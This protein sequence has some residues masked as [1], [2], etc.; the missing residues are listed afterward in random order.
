[1]KIP[2][3][4]KNVRKEKSVATR[5]HI[6]ETALTLFAKQGFTATTTKQIAQ[7]AE[8]TEGLIFYYFKTKAEIL[9]ALIET[10]HSFINKL[11]EILQNNTTSSLENLLLHVAKEWLDLLYR[12]KELTILF[13]SMAQINPRVKTALASVMNEGQKQLSIALKQKQKQNEI[14]K[15]FPIDS[16]VQI[17]FASLFNFFLTYNSLPQKSWS[18][19]SNRFTEDLISIW[20]YG[21]KNYGKN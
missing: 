6:I 1:M 20:I 12:E 7:K 10:H 19:R 16:G 4:H 13:F 2:A 3:L 15:K 14:Q 5:L 11:K 17:F 18:A 9:S 8:I 21:G